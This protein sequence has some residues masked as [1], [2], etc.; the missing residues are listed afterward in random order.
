MRCNATK[1]S[2]FMARYTPAGT[3]MGTDVCTS[4][5]TLLPIEPCGAPLF[6]AFATMKPIEHAN[7]IISPRSRICKCAVFFLI[8]RERG[9]GESQNS[10]QKV[11]AMAYRGRM[12][13][14]FEDSLGIPADERI[15]TVLC[16][17]GCKD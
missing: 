11:H 9:Q 8:E 10:L 7:F 15:S 12:V 2:M 16:A 1:L 13:L 14:F 4:H 6:E 3:I 17:C 5:A